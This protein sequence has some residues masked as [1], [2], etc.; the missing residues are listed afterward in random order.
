MAAAALIG[1]FAKPQLL[2]GKADVYVHGERL[3]RPLSIALAS[4]LV[5]ALVAPTA[6]AATRRYDFQDFQPGAPGRLA[7]HVVV[8]YKNK[9]RHGPFTP[10]QVVYD[11]NAPISC[12]PP[13]GADATAP[14]GSYI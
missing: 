8:F 13:V 2:S 1:I 6:Q 10:R 12:N 11:S 7:I 14:S 9:Q 3:K 4:L 5:A